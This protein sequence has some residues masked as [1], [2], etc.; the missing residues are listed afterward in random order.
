MSRSVIGFVTCG[1]RPEA[2]KLA[3]AVLTKKMAACV[4]VVA[5]VESHYWWQGKLHRSNEWLLVIK[6]TGARTKAV[7]E[8]IQAQ[9]SYAVPEIIFMPIVVLE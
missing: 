4:S 8:L 5:G 9:H 2:R 6:T 7:T 1:S 3:Q